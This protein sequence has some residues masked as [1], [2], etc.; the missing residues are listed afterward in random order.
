VTATQGGALVGIREN[1]L[2][3][4]IGSVVT[5]EVGEGISK[6]WMDRRTWTVTV[7]EPTT[8]L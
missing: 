1:V 8:V 6:G 3:I 2:D 7:L 4:P 5:L